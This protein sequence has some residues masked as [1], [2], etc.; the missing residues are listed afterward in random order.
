V[1]DLVWQHVH[2]VPLVRGKSLARTFWTFSIAALPQP[3]GAL[4]A[5]QF[6]ER[7][8]DLTIWSQLRIESWPET[9]G[10]LA[11]RVHAHLIAVSVLVDQYVRLEDAPE[12][13]AIGKSILTDYW[14]HL[15]GTLAVHARSAA[16]AAAEC[17]IT[18]F[19]DGEESRN[20]LKTYCDFVVDQIDAADAFAFEALKKL[21]A[22]INES[23]SGML[24]T[25][26]HV[27]IDN[28][29]A[30]QLDSGAG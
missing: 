3:D 13:D 28:E 15:R 29:L 11:R 12:P 30:R 25:L 26:A 21:N 27:A 16:A 19:K 22:N 20:N 9:V 2:V 7:P 23:V 10:G 17:P 1:L 6:I 18:L 5:W 4:E 24:A 14:D 8:V